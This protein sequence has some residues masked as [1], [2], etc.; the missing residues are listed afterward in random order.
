MAETAS[1]APK[2]ILEKEKARYEY[3]GFGLVFALLQAAAFYF[4]WPEVSKIIWSYNLTLMEEHKMSHSLFYLL[5]GLSNSAFLIIIFQGFYQ[6]CYTLELPIIER[7]KSLEEPW[8]WNDNKEEWDKLWWRSMLCY[9][10]I[11]LV[12]TPMAYCPWYVFD[13]EVELDFTMEGL[14]SSGK[15]CG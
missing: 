2:S 5:F 11:V 12:I 9:A 4:F 6:L 7:Y 14:P 15:M 1:I 13:L 10:F 8:P 3:K